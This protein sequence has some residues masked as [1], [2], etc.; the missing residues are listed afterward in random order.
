VCTMDVSSVRSLHKVVVALD[1]IGMTTQ[2]RHFVLNRAESKVGLDPHDIEA[3]VGL[4][5]DVSVPSSRA[6]PLSMNQGEP[7]IITDPKSGVARQ[8]QLLVGRFAEVQTGKPRWFGA[9]RES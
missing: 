8:M 5:I 6:V 2:Q 3:A 1:Q 4:P 9:R 7:V